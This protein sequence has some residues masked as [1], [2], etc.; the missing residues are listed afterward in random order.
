MTCSWIQYGVDCIHFWDNSNVV[1]LVVVLL[2]SFM[3]DWS[4]LKPK[5]SW[6][7]SALL[8][9]TVLLLSGQFCHKMLVKSLS[10][11]ISFLR[12]N[13]P[14]IDNFCLKSLFKRTLAQRKQIWSRC[15][16]LI[17]DTLCKSWHSSLLTQNAKWKPCKWDKSTSRDFVAWLV[18]SRPK[19]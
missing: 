6:H 4:G 14:G 2:I 10:W 16:N 13:S 1:I 7:F 17:R 12:I 8:R 5:L 3:R 9:A 11:E 18:T 15:R 19:C